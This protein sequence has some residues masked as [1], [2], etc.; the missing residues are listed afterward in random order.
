MRHVCKLCGKRVRN[1]KVN[2][3]SHNKK[4][5]GGMLRKTLS[6]GRSTGTIRLTGIYSPIGYT[7]GER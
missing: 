2:A 3:A 5:H 7:M 4:A 1:P 6:S